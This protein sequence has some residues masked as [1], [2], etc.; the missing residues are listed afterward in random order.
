MR[1]PHDLRPRRVFVYEYTCA[2][3]CPHTSLRAEGL[4]MLRAVAADFRA[5]GVTA[6]SLVGEFSPEEEE[7]RF[8]EEARRCDWTLVIAPEFDHLLAERCRWV[9]ESGGRLLGPAPD[10]VELTAD[11]LALGR[12][13]ARHGV[14][15][16]PGRPV[17]GERGCVSAPRDDDVFPAVYK[18]R[19]GAG[20]QATILVRRA[21][22]LPACVAQAHAEFPHTEGVLQ[23]WVPGLAASVAFLIGPRQRLAMLP[24]TQRLSE[25]GRFQYRGGEIPFPEPLAWRAVRLARQAVEC[26]PG[27]FGYVGVDLILGEEA[28]GHGDQ[29]IE[30]N[31]RLTTSYLGLRQLATEPLAGTLLRV[32]AGKEVRLEW[33]PGRASFQP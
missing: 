14:L 27:L 3:P 1:E 8:R 26:V 19:H 15:T 10:A 31:P 32:A 33:H 18:P 22:E 13:F 2:R 4:A 5:A 24:A 29:V 30:I 16:P 28:D 6:V 7:R 20:S 25:D 17:H 12:H 21:E 11:K 23:P 9:V